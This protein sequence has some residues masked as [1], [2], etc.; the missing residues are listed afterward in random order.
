[1][2]IV[3]ELPLS[4][5]TICLIVCRLIEH[6]MKRKELQNKCPLVRLSSCSKKISPISSLNGTS[7][8]ASMFD[9]TL[10]GTVLIVPS[11][12]Q[13]ESTQWPQSET[14][15]SHIELLVSNKW[16]E[17]ATTAEW[18]LQRKWA[19]DVQR[20]SFLIVR[21]LF[22]FKRITQRKECEGE[23]YWPSSFTGTERESNGRCFVRSTKRSCHSALSKPSK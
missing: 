13:I 18:T 12:M 8:K 21:A 7:Q 2:L 4:R 20:A 19:I 5:N 3:F 22:A 14:Q 11:F 10:V 6:R 16:Q 9:W 15:S 17:N 23:S 1:M